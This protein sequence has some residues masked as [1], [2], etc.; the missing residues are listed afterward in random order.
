MPIQFSVIEGNALNYK[1]DVL[2]LKYAQYPYGVDRAVINIFSDQISNFQDGLPKIG[3]IYMVS[4]NELIGSEQIMFVGVNPLFQ[5]GYKELREFSFKILSKLSNREDIKTISTTL[6]GVGFGLDE[7][8]AFESEIVGFHDAI[9]KG[10]YPKSLEEII[11]IENRRD[12]VIRLTTI[13][14]SILPNGVYINDQYSSKKRNANLYS[15]KLRSIGYLSDSKP[16]IFVAMPFE[17]KLDD[18]FHYGIQGAVN[19]TGFLCERADLS[20]F[21]GDIL[22]HIKNRIKNASLVIADLTNANPNV[23]LEV[24]YAWGIGVR[25]ILLVQDFADL[26]F[27]VKGQKCLRY[28]KIK[29]L[30]DLLKTELEKLKN[31]IK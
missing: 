13:L 5:F 7:T 10:L 30:E 9:L 19:S 20:S 25:T 29:D 16:Y 11:F 24:G 12:R 31:V 6:H 4:S 2:A 27:D 23:Y 22:I 18:L 3:D 14:S 17:E 26:K 8:E 15:E 1:T 28:S 21:T